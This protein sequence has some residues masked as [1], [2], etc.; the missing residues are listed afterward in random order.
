MQSYL[1]LEKRFFVKP[2]PSFFLVTTFAGKLLAKVSTWRFFAMVVS[3]CAPETWMHAV[4]QSTNT[5]RVKKAQFFDIDFRIDVLRRRERP[6][7]L[8]SVPQRAGVWSLPYS[9]GK[10]RRS[11]VTFSHLNFSRS[12]VEMRIEQYYRPIRPPRCMFLFVGKHGARLRLLH[13][14]AV[15]FKCTLRPLISR[16][17]FRILDARASI[18]DAMKGWAW[19][20]LFRSSR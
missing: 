5:N 3:A 12:H 8:R 14:Q 18:S 13:S 9:K 15:S 19:Q 2:S 1:Y 10:R 16:S 7:R 4:H 11:L 6:A 20:E 17:L